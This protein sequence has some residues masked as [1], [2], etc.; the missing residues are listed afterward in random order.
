MEKLVVAGTGQLSI[1]KTIKDFQNSFKSELETSII[2]Y[3]TKAFSN[4]YLLKVLNE[5]DMNIDVVTGGELAIAKFIEFPS[6]R[7]NFHGNNKTIDEL[8]EALDYGFKHIKIDS[9]NEIQNIK[10][11]LSLMRFLVFYF[12][13][14][15]NQKYLVDILDLIQDK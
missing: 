12:R 8:K 13:E 4:P 10:H 9:F 1:L 11:S 2:S 3:S 5:N 14:K 15:I 6:N 7:I